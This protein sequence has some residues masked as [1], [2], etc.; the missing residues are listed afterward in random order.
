MR[1]EKQIKSS[2]GMKSICEERKNSTS[3]S[4]LLPFKCLCGINM[5]YVYIK[6]IF[7]FLYICLCVCTHGK[8]HD[9]EV[10]FFPSCQI[11]RDIDSW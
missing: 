4:Q 5:I 10:R 7:K 11:D 1:L 2:Q 6:G 9:G 3:P 8:S